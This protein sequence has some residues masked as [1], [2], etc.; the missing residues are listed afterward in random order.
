VKVWRSLFHAPAAQALDD[1]HTRDVSAEDSTSTDETPSDA[2]HRLCTDTV[3]DSP[4]VHA[5]NFSENFSLLHLLKLL[6]S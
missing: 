1:R 2:Y 4:A 5:E 3:L 6:L